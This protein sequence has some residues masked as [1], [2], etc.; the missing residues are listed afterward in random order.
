[1]FLVDLLK[2][3]PL[4]QF[5]AQENPQSVLALSFF[6]LFVFSGS[7]FTFQMS[8]AF[9]SKTTANR[10]KSREDFYAFLSC[11]APANSALGGGWG[12]N[13]AGVCTSSQCVGVRGNIQQ[14]APLSTARPKGFLWAVNTYIV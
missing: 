9:P 6:L 2:F 7:L 13:A 1:M 11:L 8:H 14:A 3:Y 12:P 10:K 5:S 4:S